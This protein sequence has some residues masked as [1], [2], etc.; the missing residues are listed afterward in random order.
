[1][2]ASP[3]GQLVLNDGLPD[4]NGPG[5]QAVPPLVVGKKV[6]MTLCPV[7]G[8]RFGARR[9]VCLHW[10]RTFRISFGPVSAPFSSYY[11]Y[12]L[13]NCEITFVDVTYHSLTPIDTI[14]LQSLVFG[15]RYDVS[16][17]T[18]SI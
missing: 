11:C 2:S 7:T 16:G 1:M 4:P 6:S 12:C 9:F 5:T 13:N 10:D 15:L 8:I 3:F 17:A 18:R 14:I